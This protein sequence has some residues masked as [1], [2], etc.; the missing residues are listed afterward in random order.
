MY[1]GLYCK[2]S[3]D[4]LHEKATL[5]GS[6]TRARL[7]GLI[8][9][10]FTCA[11]RWLLDHLSPAPL[12]LCAETLQVFDTSHK[13]AIRRKSTLFQADCEPNDCTIPLQPWQT[14]PPG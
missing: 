2:R 3:L 4:M 14:M 11:S 13:T 7:H 6:I 8:I 10:F 5:T 9:V 1:T 12:R